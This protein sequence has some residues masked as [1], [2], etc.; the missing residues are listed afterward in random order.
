MDITA[1]ATIWFATVALAS[2]IAVT[3]KAARART[4]T[5]A[6]AACHTPHPP[7]VNGVSTIMVLY[8]VI[9]KGL[10]ATLCDLQTKLGSVFTISFF[11]FK[12]SFLLGPE[13]S[14]HFYQASDTEISHGNILEFTVPIIGKEV[15]YGTDATTRNDQH[16][17]FRD[18]LKPSKVGSRIGAV[19]QE[20]EVDIL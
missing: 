10:R 3:S 11:G 8:K 12:V 4:T 19:L 20:V 2:I 18:V 14:A 5:V 16:R 9:T 7:V 1:S 6:P 17:F 15:A 13:I